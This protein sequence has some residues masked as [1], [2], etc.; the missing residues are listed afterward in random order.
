M[1]DGTDIKLISII[2][3]IVLVADLIILVLLK[4]VGASQNI[5]Y[6]AMVL[7]NIVITVYILLKHIPQKILIKIE[8]KS[9]M[10]SKS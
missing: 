7:V 8:G 9:P 6:I 1:L 3:A 5:S 10:E 4:A 2:Y